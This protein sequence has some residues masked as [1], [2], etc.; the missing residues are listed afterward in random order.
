MKTGVSAR[1]A[2]TAICHD[3]GSGTAAFPTLTFPFVVEKFSEL[4]LESRRTT[5]ARFTPLEP[6]ATALKS[7]TTRTPEPFATESGPRRL[8]K[9][10]IIPPPTLSIVPGMKKVDPAVERKLPSVTLVADKTLGLNPISN[11]KAARSA[12]LEILTSTANE[13]PAVTFEEIGW[14]LTTLSAKPKHESKRMT[15]TV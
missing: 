12:T 9:L 1:N 6:A 11:V 7:I 15:A 3:G 14:I 10:N 4:P 5:L 2:Y 8:S 13:L